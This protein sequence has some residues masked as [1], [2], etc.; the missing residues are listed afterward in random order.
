MRE[1]VNDKARQGTATL[2]LVSVVLLLLLLAFAHT[3][4][5]QML[6]LCLSPKTQ[7]EVN[8]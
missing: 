5:K 1:A 3:T 2:L 4:G 7:E 6:L 8:E